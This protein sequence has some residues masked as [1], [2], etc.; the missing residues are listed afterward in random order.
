MTSDVVY[1]KESLDKNLLPPMPGVTAP[2][3]CL[4]I[5]QRIRHIRDAKNARIFY[6]HD[7]EIFKAT[8]VAPDFYD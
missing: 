4:K 5:Y 3:R 2:G 8:K 1:L 6:G 7:P